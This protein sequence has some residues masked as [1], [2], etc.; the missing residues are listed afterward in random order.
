MRK[1]Y[2]DI[3]VTLKPI[4]NEEP[5]ESEFRMAVSYP[6][7]YEKD[8][9]VNLKQMKK[10]KKQFLKIMDM[11][12]FLKKYENVNEF[13]FEYVVIDKAYNEVNGQRLG[14]TTSPNAPITSVVSREELSKKG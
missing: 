11:S 2:T 5:V 4:I 10:A 7:C 1:Y 3:Y 13:I 6:F 9:F 8:A 12:K 14:G